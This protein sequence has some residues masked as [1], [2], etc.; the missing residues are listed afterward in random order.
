MSEQKRL[1]IM[2][3]IFG[4]LILA[5]LYNYVIVDDFDNTGFFGGSPSIGN[6]SPKVRNALDALKGAPELNFRFERNGETPDFEALRN[7]FIFGVDQRVQ[8]ERQAEMAR[9]EAIREEMAQQ[10]QQAAQQMQVQQVEADP[11]S[12]ALRDFGGKVL[13]IMEDKN[14]AQRVAVIRL[15]QEILIIGPGTDV[16][17]GFKCIAIDYGQVT[18]ERKQ[19]GQRFDISLETE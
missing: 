10:A 12:E 19:D 5:N 3:A 6:Y 1:T 11:E 14:E 16:G 4:V 15:D 8:Q 13:G 7:P 18:L 17:D 2:G 9:L